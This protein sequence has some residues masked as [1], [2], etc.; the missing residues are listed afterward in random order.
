[1]ILD[2]NRLESRIRRILSLFAALLLATNL[3]PAA[4]PPLLYPKHA[5]LISYPVLAKQA[6]IQGT[7][8]VRCF[9]DPA[10]RV[11]AAKAIEGHPVLADPTVQNSLKWSFFTD[12]SLS[13]ESLQ[14]DLRY[15]YKI[16]GLESIYREPGTQTL[17]ELPHRILITAK[18]ARVE[19]LETERPLEGQK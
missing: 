1:M 10:G 14:V 7:V 19:A 6:R 4:T 15:E 12:G 3:T 8:V 2:R 13:K 17:I 18:A 16:V 5:E 11:V 9:L